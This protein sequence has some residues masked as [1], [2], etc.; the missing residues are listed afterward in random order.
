MILDKPIIAID[1]DGTITT[2]DNRIWKDNT[3]E[4]DIFFENL[5]ITEFIKKYRKEFYLVLWTCRS[6]ESLEQAISYSKSI[7]IEFDAINANMSGVFETSNKIYAD[8]YLDDKATFNV[9]DIKH[10]CKIL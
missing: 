9:E 7:G 3:P 10:K 2:G 6:K 5:N 1:F 8:F 4:N